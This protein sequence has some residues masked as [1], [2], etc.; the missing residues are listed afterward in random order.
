MLHSNAS[1][2]DSSVYAIPRHMITTSA[3]APR[4]D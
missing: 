1:M 2:S 3:A 4:D